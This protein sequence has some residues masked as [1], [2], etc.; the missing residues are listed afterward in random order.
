MTRKIKNILSIVL[1]SA[2]CVVIFAVP[3]SARSSYYLSAYRAWLTAE[4]NGKILVTVDV[5]GTGDMEKIGATRIEILESKNN[6]A[7]WTQYRVFL[8]SIFP[9]MLTS[10]D[11][12]YY[13]TP[14]SFT[15]TPGYKYCAIVTVYARDSTGSDSREYTTPMVTAKN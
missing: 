5:Q 6:G 9:E 8:S 7:S 14:V 13:D 3:A 1:V 10:G 12:L 2:L 4:S 11:Y 15:G